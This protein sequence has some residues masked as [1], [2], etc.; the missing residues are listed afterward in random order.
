[1]T[2]PAAVRNL[3]PPLPLGKK[4]ILKMVVSWGWT[5]A[6]ALPENLSQKKSFPLNVP[7]T[8]RSPCICKSQIDVLIFLAKIRQFVSLISRVIIFL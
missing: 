6:T 7:P 3:A 5:P 1:M 2:Y 8:I 4:T